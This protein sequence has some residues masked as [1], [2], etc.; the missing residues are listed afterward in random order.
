MGAW[1]GLAVRLQVR[2][3]W[4]DSTGACLLLHFPFLSLTP[5]TSTC[6]LLSL[7]THALSAHCQPPVC[8]GP[9]AVGVVGGGGPH[10]HPHPCGRIPAR[11]G[12]WLRVSGGTT[13]GGEALDGWRGEEPVQAI[14]LASHAARPMPRSSQAHNLV[15]NRSAAGY[16]SNQCRC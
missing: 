9:G 12:T 11:R 1:G 16:Q 10:L 4:G 2:A 8:C 3:R 7:L 6:R 5:S 13:G 14:R 15:I